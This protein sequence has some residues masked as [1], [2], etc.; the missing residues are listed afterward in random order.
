MSTAT[1]ATRRQAKKA[2]IPQVTPKK[3]ELTSQQITRM[4]EELVKFPNPSVY[5]KK[6]LAAKFAKEFGM[7]DRIILE[8]LNKNGN[9]DF[10]LKVTP[11]PSQPKME[12]KKEIVE[13]PSK[14]QPAKDASEIQYI[15]LESDTDD[16]EVLFNESNTS[17]SVSLNEKPTENPVVKVKPTQSSI[18]SSSSTGD[19][20]RLK[21]SN[22][23]LEKKVM[24]LEEKNKA[25]DISKDM[26]VKYDDLF[27]EY[28]E[29]VEI[30]K[31]L[32]S[33][34]PRMISEFKK[35]V[36]D[37]ETKHKNNLDE[38][39][40]V[41]K[42]IQEEHSKISKSESDKTVKKL[43]QQ[44]KAKEAELLLTKKDLV[45]HK[46]KVIND[47]D[48][49][50]KDLEDQLK[51]KTV[52]LEATKK[53][54]N[55]HKD[56]QEA[57]DNRY[58]KL[59]KKQEKDLDRANEDSQELIAKIKKMKEDYSKKN[60]Q[61]SKDLGELKDANKKLRKELDNKEKESKKVSKEKEDAFN[62]LENVK[63][64]F[65][66]KVSKLEE[67]LKKK[68]KAHDDM[69]Q[70]NQT[71]SVK[72][73]EVQQVNTKDK[74]KFEC[75]LI[76]IQAELK[77]VKADFTKKEEKFIEANEKLRE[78]IRQLELRDLECQEKSS[79]S[80][81]EISDLKK[82]ASNLETEKK[83]LSD[84]L[85]AKREESA[86]NKTVIFECK[87]EIENA[88]TLIK[89]STKDISERNNIIAEQKK[90]L[91][92]VEKSNKDMTIVLQEL[93]NEVERKRSSSERLQEI[94]EK[95][96]E[97]EYALLKLK[98]VLFEKD[99]LISTKDAE[100]QKLSSRIHEIKRDFDKKME[101][102]G[103]EEINNQNNLRHQLL[104]QQQDM[105][106]VLL[107][108]QDLLKQ[109]MAEV[110]VNYENIL[111]AAIK[112]A[113]EIQDR[114]ETKLYQVIEQKKAL[115]VKVK[116]ALLYKPSVG[117]GQE[118][119]LKSFGSIA[120]LGYNWPLVH[121]HV[122]LE[123]ISEIRPTKA[124]E[125]LFKLKI[126][127]TKSIGDLV[128]TKQ[129]KKGIKRGFD[130]GQATTSKR[131]K[132]DPP[133]LMISF[134]WPVALYHKKTLA[135]EMR[136]DVMPLSLQT[137]PAPVVEYQAKKK[138]KRRFEKGKDSISKR[139]KILF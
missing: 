54:F 129:F 94:T 110:K 128:A 35:Y 114:R 135:L 14:P 25:K 36:E 60:P 87:A 6:K 68:V 15:D 65:E 39:E 86:S 105:R 11:I 104:V 59:I 62:K 127:I 17:D 42:K 121:K 34:I 107:A 74:A 12:I 7:N 119:S 126:P 29:K 83:A 131:F 18:K 27:K 89:S 91:E 88:K 117:Q 78:K 30:V 79:Q 125:S 73:K 58:R 37:L 96:K 13:K 49:K 108:E 63:T 99:N 130:E 33:Q 5:Y 64:N 85:E 136:V 98:N 4:E 47:N 56:N 48:K 76:D 23:D 122:D 138:L 45:N 139:F 67:D 44:L 71:L 57:M 19:V 116:K 134:S 50:A 82:R 28:K 90:K 9:R 53:E 80:V 40:E 93:K 137:L 106:K 43:Q 20:E 16:S 38:K 113:E 100:I 133:V 111:R 10:R 55:E 52:E 3:E 102:R 132:A 84:E 69:K 66:K 92:N 2:S 77:N 118:K 112:E 61:F 22:L 21:K 101:N 24:E 109:Q 72:I 75:D 95:V 120:A 46:E 31:N 41:L 81:Q 124:L 26:K 115:L 103:F 123:L 32:E 8:W 1:R 70:E 51:K 97:K